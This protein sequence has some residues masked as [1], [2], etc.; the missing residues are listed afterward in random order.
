MWKPLSKSWSNIKFNTLSEDKQLCLLEESTDPEE[1]KQLL[2][3]YFSCS[4]TWLRRTRLEEI[5]PEKLQYL[6]FNGILTVEQLG[7]K[8]FHWAIELMLAWLMD[9]ADREFPKLTKEQLSFVLENANP[10]YVEILLRYQLSNLTEEQFHFVLYS[11]NS[12]KFLVGGFLRRHC[13]NLTEK[14]FRDAIHRLESDYV[15]YFLSHYL[16]DLTKEQFCGLAEKVIQW[17]PA[18]WYAHSDAPPVLTKLTKKQFHYVVEKLNSVCLVKFLYNHFFKITKKRFCHVLGKLDTNSLKWLLFS[19]LLFLTKGYRALFYDS[20]V[21]YLYGQTL[22]KRKQ[23]RLREQCRLVR[24]TLKGKLFTIR[25]GRRLIVILQIYQKTKTKDIVPLEFMV[26]SCVLKY[27]EDK[28]NSLT[29][30][31]SWLNDIRD[32][33]EK[34]LADFKWWWLNDIENYSNSLSKLR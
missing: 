6:L 13:F 18:L 34:A 5:K 19:F 7:K 10:T 28:M 32:E 17:C 23:Q 30:D 8:L 31:D 21:S 27:L 1:L 4:D 12:S 25:E 29:H 9:H 2:F 16:F 15:R 22:T 24:W 3:R 33:E 11:L 26:I 20:S 14:Q